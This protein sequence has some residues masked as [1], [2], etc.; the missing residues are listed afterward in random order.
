MKKI[1]AIALMV[2]IFTG[3]KKDGDGPGDNTN[4]CST[5]S[6][7]TTANAGSVDVSLNASGYGFYEIEYGTNGFSLGNGTKQTINSNTTISNLTNGTYD[8]YLR[9]NCGGTSWSDWSNPQSFLIQ[10]GNSSTCAKPTN[11]SASGGYLNWANQGADYYEVEYGVTG[12]T[13]GTGTK[14]TVSNYWYAS[15]AYAANT[16]YDFYVRANCGGT[17]F[18]PWSDAKSF[19][20]QNNINMCLAPTNLSAYRNGGVIEYSFDANGE[21]QYEI[22]VSNSSSPNGG[23]IIGITSTQGAVSGIYSNVSYNVF[24]RSVCSNGSRTAW[25]GPVYIP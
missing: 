9:G 18:S 15:G 10:G 14:Q 16:T 22:V 8:I 25:T 17:D 20:N 21:D 19:Y 1:L 7:Y 24:V 11:L 6:F 2:L 12:F 13:L 3:C 23:N 5:P 4:P